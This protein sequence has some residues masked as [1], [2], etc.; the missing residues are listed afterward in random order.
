MSEIHSIIFKKKSYTTSRAR[1]WL[2]KH[3]FKPIKRVHVTENFYRYRIEPPEKYKCF[4]TKYITKDIAF[5]FGFKKCRS[6]KGGG[7]HGTHRMGKEWV[8]RYMQV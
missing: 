3:N 5:V 6:K 1:Y 4:A 7:F 2:K 8:L